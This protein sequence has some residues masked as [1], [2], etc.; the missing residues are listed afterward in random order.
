MTASSP[1]ATATTATTP[2][3]SSTLPYTG[4]NLE[5][6]VGVGIGLLGAGVL[7]RRIVRRA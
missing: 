4:L 3:S 2:D 6:C 5:A 1:S 7:L